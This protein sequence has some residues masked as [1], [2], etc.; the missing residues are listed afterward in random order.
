[1]PGIAVREILHR[2][3]DQRMVRYD[4]LCAQLPGLA[5]NS[6]S[7][8]ECQQRAMHLITAAAKLEPGVIKAHLLF[9]RRKLA[10]I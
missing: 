7:D 8:V 3:K 6:V 5:D 4:K 1:M 2:S 9:K 10:E